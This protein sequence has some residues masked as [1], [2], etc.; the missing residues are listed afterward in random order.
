[1][2]TIK[3]LANTKRV[4]YRNRY[5]RE[6]EN[7]SQQ[8]QILNPSIKKITIEPLHSYVGQLLF[9]NLYDEMKFNHS[10]DFIY[11]SFGYDRNR[12]G[13]VVSI[14]KLAYEN[15]VMSFS[16]FAYKHAVTKKNVNDYSFACHMKN[17]MTTFLHQNFSSYTFDEI[18]RNMHQIFNPSPFSIGYIDGFNCR[19]VFGTAKIRT[20]QSILPLHTYSINSEGDDDDD[21]D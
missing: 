20:K 18:S 21:E 6:K 9:L 10:M 16:D 17:S 11:K 3:Q 8:R 4:V 15:D 14:R 13:E 1:M 7:Q 12:G 2:V 19:D 5:N